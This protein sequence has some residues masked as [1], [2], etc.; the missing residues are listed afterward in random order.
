MQTFTIVLKMTGLLLLTP[1]DDTRGPTH[2]LLPEPNGAG[3]HVAQIGYVQ[4]ECASRRDGICWVSLDGM[5]LD[6]GKGGGDQERKALSYRAGN[7]TRRM[8][9]RVRADHDTENPTGVRS[10]VSLF[11]G[12]VTDY[13]SLANWVYA[14][15]ADEQSGG[16]VIPLANLLTWT[17]PNAGPGNLVLALRQMNGGSQRDSIILSPAHDTIELFIRHVPPGDTLPPPED[18]VPEEPLPA[19]ASHFTAY[20]EYLHVAPTAQLPHHPTW[21]TTPITGSKKR[22]PWRVSRGVDPGRGVGTL[23][24]MIAS[25]DPQ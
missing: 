4:P 3:H 14:R 9:G 25:A 7:L 11:A 20:Y 17:I 15:S 2:V 16:A 23:H 5:L 24:C 1:H 19:F 18:P 6:I 22:C 21:I 10:R 13:C 12:R 8:G